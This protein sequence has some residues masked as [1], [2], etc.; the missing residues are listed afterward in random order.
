MLAGALLLQ[1]RMRRCWSLTG[2]QC[3]AQAVSPTPQGRSA[4]AIAIA[5]SITAD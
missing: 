5:I 3:S 4:A 1:T 2:S